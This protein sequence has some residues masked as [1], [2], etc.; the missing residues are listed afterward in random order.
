[1]SHTPNPPQ[2]GSGP[3]GIEIEGLTTHPR[4]AG[5][6]WEPTTKDKRLRREPEAPRP[7][8]KTLGKKS[9]IFLYAS[10]FGRTGPKEP[11]EFS[12]K[13]RRKEIVKKYLIIKKKI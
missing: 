6:G 5:S 1:L 13:T 10:V 8:D 3:E 11:S 12:R 9:K 2:R 7:N 4:I